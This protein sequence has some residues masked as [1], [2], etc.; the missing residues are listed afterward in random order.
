MQTPK[1]LPPPT[2]HNH[3]E[4]HTHTQTSIRYACRLISN[5]IVI[6]TVL[7]WYLSLLDVWSYFQRQSYYIHT[8]LWCHVAFFFSGAHIFIISFFICVCACAHHCLHV[9]L[10]SF[11]STV[12]WNLYWELS[13]KFTRR[14]LILL[15]TFRQSKL[16]VNGKRV[17]HTARARARMWKKKHHRKHSKKCVNE[18]AKML[19]AGNGS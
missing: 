3:E 16:I 6:A 1:Q 17:R 5:S 4:T 11:I 12:S 13:S 9:F 15:R 2:I 19:V 10:I 8:I 18:H 14:P 7:L